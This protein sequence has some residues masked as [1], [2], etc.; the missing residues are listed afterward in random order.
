[1]ARDAAGN[2]TTSSGKTV[3][4]KNAP[5]PPP[6]VPANLTP[7]A[8][9]PSQIN[10]SWKASTDATGYNVYRNGTK[11]A[12]ATSTSYSDTGLT[13]KTTYRYA[14]AAYNA[15][16]TSAKSSAVS[17]TTW[18]ALS[19]KFAKGDRVRANKLLDVFDTPSTSGSRLG[20]QKSGSQG[21][22][23]G[24]PAYANG[25]WWWNVNFDSGADGWI[26][27]SNLSKIAVTP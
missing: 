15:N 19:T 2:Q 17:A 25:F 24:G 22:V 23:T 7:I 14:V 13:A 26:I 11:I 3:T 10:L 20:T 6:P 5:P 12:S 21:A 4:V 8:V 1:M 9:S 16:G 18:P 27:Q